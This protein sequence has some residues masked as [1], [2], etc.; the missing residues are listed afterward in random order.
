MDQKQRV[1]EPPVVGIHQRSPPLPPE[2]VHQI[3]LEVKD[4]PK[5]QPNHCDSEPKD[6]TS[7]SSDEECGGSYGSTLDLLACSLVCNDWYNEARPLLPAALNPILISDYQRYKTK[8]LKRF[9]QLLAK[10]CRLH[11]YPWDAIT[12]LT[13]INP[14]ALIDPRTA[15]YCDESAEAYKIVLRT[16][17]NLRVLR[18]YYDAVSGRP[19][20]SDDTIQHLL[21]FF[22]SIIPLCGAITGLSLEL[23]EGKQGEGLFTFIPRLI[24]ALADHLPF[25]EINSSDLDDSMQAALRRCTGLHEIRILDSRLYRF[26]PILPFWPNLQRFRGSWYNMDVA[27][28]EEFLRTLAESCPRLNE[29]I[30]SCTDDPSSS[31]GFNPGI[32]PIAIRFALRCPELRRLS[33][34]CVR[35]DAGFVREL[36]QAQPQL[37]RLHLNWC[38]EL[39]A[40]ESLLEGLARPIWPEM[41][42]LLMESWYRAEI[43]FV[44][45]LVRECPRLELVAVPEIWESYKGFE[46][47]MRE[48]GFD[49]TRVYNLG[50]D[51]WSSVIEWA[52]T[53]VETG[54]VAS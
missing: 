42:E 2:L 48:L 14:K 35:L 40:R 18:I 30:L 4:N 5:S 23:Y 54:G 25:L 20:C 8:E 26:A 33:V 11:L 46:R 34:P 51:I 32:S 7:E 21:R 49:Y 19:E 17:P 29:V 24:E 31:E 45:R 15:M 39:E 3:L 28:M 41:R 47:V 6:D 1:G 27:L 50:D 10:S 38:F 44:E 53:R 16:A 22:D 36:M 9:A 13:I 52:W 12:E 43:G 37:E